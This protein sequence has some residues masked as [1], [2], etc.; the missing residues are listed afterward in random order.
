MLPEALRL[1]DKTS[2]SEVIAL[3]KTFQIHHEAIQ[4]LLH[5]AIVGASRDSEQLAE[6][7]ARL[8]ALLEEQVHFCRMMSYF[9]IFLSD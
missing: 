8:E 4:S 7:L 3:G 5:G 6:E 9:L 2:T 1:L